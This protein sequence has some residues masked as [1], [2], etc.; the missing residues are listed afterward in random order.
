MIL[1]VKNRSASVV[2]Y[3]IPEAG[4]R[5][6]FQIGEVKKIDKEELD[7]LIFTPGGREL[8][9]D[10]LLITNQE[11]TSDLGIKTEPEYYMTEKEIVELIVSGSLDAWLDALDFAPVGVIDLMKKLSVTVPLTDTNKIAALQKK[12]GFN[13]MKALENEKADKETE[14]PFVD[15][16]PT[17]RVQKPV[18][19]EKTEPTRRTS[20]TQYKNIVIK[21]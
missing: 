14:A 17:R 9:Q 7:K 10:Y 13:A 21:G 5:R 18:A 1:N 19:E 16:T 12:T 2:G 11:A 20:G 15:K 4:I 6:E 3:A 8:I